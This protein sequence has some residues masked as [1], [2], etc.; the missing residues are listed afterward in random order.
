MKKFYSLL[1]A[2]AICTMANAQLEFS[3]DFESYSVGD[4]IG[5]NS[6]FWT[7]WSGATGGARYFLR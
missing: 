4:Y 1:S 2:L 7:T 6:S 3:D 5:A